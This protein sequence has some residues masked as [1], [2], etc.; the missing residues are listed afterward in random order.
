MVG[1][2]EKEAGVFAVRTGCGLQG[3]AVHAGDDL[4]A[5]L[6]GVHHFQSALHR[7]LRCQG[8]DVRE[9]REATGD[10][11]HRRVVFHGARAQRI[12]AMI[13]AE[14][15]LFQGAI[16]TV[17]FH[18]VQL[19]QVQRLL[20][21]RNVH[22]TGWYVRRREEVHLVTFA[23]PFKNQF[24]FIHLLSG[25]KSAHRFLLCYSLR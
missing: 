12:E 9:A 2:D 5:F 18:F 11:I 8:M 6:Q 4:E 7:G 16:V 24:H 1:A 21:E 19:R 15:F 22:G 25:W 3:E 10:F 23:G 14:G 13:Y 20:A 17:E